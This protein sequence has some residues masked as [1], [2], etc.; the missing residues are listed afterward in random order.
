MKRLAVE[1]NIYSKMYDV[2]IKTKYLQ[3]IQCISTNNTVFI[4]HLDKLNL[5]WWLPQLHQKID[6]TTKRNKI[7]YRTPNA[8][9]KSLIHSCKGKRLFIVDAK[10]KIKL[11]RYTLLTKLHGSL[12]KLFTKQ[13]VSTIFFQIRTFLCFY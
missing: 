4:R 7:N 2:S 11:K 13:F 9:P 8:K 6:F 1:H 5:F 3:L 12:L 10:P